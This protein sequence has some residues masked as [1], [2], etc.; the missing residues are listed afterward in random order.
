M[1]TSS[2]DKVLVQIRHKPGKYRR[3][4]KHNVPRPR[5]FGEITKKCVRC[6]RTGAH[7]SKYGIDLCR[8]CF[9]EAAP[10]LGFKKFN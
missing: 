2:Y 7:V 9:R 6:G 3:W 8:Q 1:T 10:R 5:K 4:Q